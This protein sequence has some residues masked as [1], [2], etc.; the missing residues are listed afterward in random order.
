MIGKS[1]TQNQ[2]NHFWNI[3]RFIEL[4]TKQPVP[5]PR[6]LI[7]PKQTSKLPQI[8]LWSTTNRWIFYQISECKSP[9][10][11]IKPP[12]W[13]LSD[14][15]SANNWHFFRLSRSCFNQSAEVWTQPPLVVLLS[16]GSFL[17]LETFFFLHRQWLSGDASKNAFDLFWWVESCDLT[18][19]WDVLEP[20]YFDQIRLYKIGNALKDTGPA[21]LLLS[22][23]THVLC[24]HRYSICAS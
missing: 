18:R 13:K 16:S 9:W 1:T 2:L 10:T 8:E 11:N 7:P 5:S 3:C 22:D 12:Y 24:R 14:D 15:G 6:G 20:N 4:H 23:K 17:T 19:F 21:F